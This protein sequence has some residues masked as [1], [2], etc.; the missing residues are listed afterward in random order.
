MKIIPVVG[1]GACSFCFD[2]YLRFIIISYFLVSSVACVSFAIC[3]LPVALPQVDGTRHRPDGGARHRFFLHPSLISVFP[4]S[5][6][7]RSCFS[8]LAL[9][10]YV[11]TR[12]FTLFCLFF[13]FYLFQ[14]IFFLYLMEY[15]SFIFS[16]AMYRGSWRMYAV[17]VVAQHHGMALYY[18]CLQ[19]SRLCYT[20]ACISLG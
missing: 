14:L 20:S 1:W 7:R 2:G 18:C 16:L 9:S 10:P 4:V 11:Y 8:A 19:G 13:I 3:L 12:N 6:F 17:L 5:F 15:D